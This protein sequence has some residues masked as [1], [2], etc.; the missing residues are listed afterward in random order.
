MNNKIHHDVSIDDLD[1]FTLDKIKSGAIT[2]YKDRVKS[3][4]TAL[5]IENFMIY[6]KNNNFKIVAVEKDHKLLTKENV[7]AA[8]KEGVHSCP[9]GYGL[10]EQINTLMRKLGF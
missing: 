1:R 8:I 4:T 3:N 6:L 7:R 10:V 9:T 5:V 2:D